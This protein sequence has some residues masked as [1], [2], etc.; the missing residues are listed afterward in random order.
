[1]EDDDSKKKGRRELEAEILDK[2][3]GVIAAVNDAKHVDDVVCALHS[4]AVRLFPLDSRAISGTP[5]M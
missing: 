1:M 5:I 4:L 3:G 2:V